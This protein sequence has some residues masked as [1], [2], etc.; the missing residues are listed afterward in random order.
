MSDQCKNICVE[1]NIGAGKSTLLGY[2]SQYKNKFSINLDI[3][4]EPLEQWINLNGENLFALYGQR[5]DL[6]SFAFESFIQMTLLKRDRQI[7]ASTK[8]IRVFERSMLSA[9]YVF[10]QAL[11]E[12]KHLS[13]IEYDIL[14]QWFDILKEFDFSIKPDIIIYLK[15]SPALLLTRINSRGRDG[16]QNLG[17]SYLTELHNLYESWIQG[18]Q[19][20]QT[21]V[22]ITLNANKSL[23][24]LTLDFEKL[25]TD[26]L[27]SANL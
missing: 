7:Q 3:F 21:P 6:W 2:M 27:Q 8:P 25:C 26:L 15:T 20:S 18:I 5:P 23:A 11:F 14:N 19:L 1:G 4:N 16:E 24:E 13:Q 9:R 22:V 10:T 12:K 17:E